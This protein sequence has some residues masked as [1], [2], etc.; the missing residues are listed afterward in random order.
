MHDDVP[1]LPTAAGATEPN[2]AFVEQVRAAFP[3]PSGAIIV[4]CRSGTRSAKACAVLQ[5][6][7]LIA[8]T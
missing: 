8:Q 7:G 2:A 6:V 1:T 3:D 5:Q 4:G